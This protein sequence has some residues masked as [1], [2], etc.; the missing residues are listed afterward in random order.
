[1]SLDS[2]S[3][4]SH[5]SCSLSHMCPDPP[6]AHLSCL[7]SHISILLGPPQG[8]MELMQALTALSPAGSRCLAGGSWVQSSGHWDSPGLLAISPEASGHRSGLWEGMKVG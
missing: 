4:L 3:P 8:S 7:L 5:L 6:Q 1:M 2:A